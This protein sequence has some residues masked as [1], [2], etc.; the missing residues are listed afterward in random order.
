MN[1]NGAGDEA[2]PARP[3]RMD[4]DAAAV[5]HN[6]A[7]LRAHVGQAVRLFVALKGNACGFGTVPAARLVAASGADALAVVDV[8]D[9]VAIRRAGI[10]LPILL[11]G[12]NIATPAAVAAVRRFDMMPTLHDDVSVAGFANSATDPLRVFVEV[13][14]GGER[15]GFEPTAVPR[16]LAHLASRPWI[17]VAGI[18]AHMH[19][20]ENPSGL[21]VVQ[22]Q[23]GRF[24]ALLRDLESSGIRIPVQMTASSKTLLVSSSMNLTA[25]DPGHLVFGVHPGGPRR[26]ELGL[27][28]ALLR[29]TSR[30]VQVRCVTR[31]AFVDQAP[32]KVRPGQRIGVIPFGASD[33]LARVNAGV[34]LVRGKRVPLLGPPSAEHARLD[35]DEVPDATA[36]DEVTIIGGEAAATISLDEVC[37]H[38]AGVRESDVTRSIG[39]NIPRLYVEEAAER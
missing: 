16:L 1:S 28:P 5:R 29:L 36:G 21:A 19:V 20:P 22:W 33:G 3:N 26:P 17:T 13:N 32:S 34:V 12:G 35:L 6:I 24:H 4:V 14:V 23:F 8:G 30:L 31:P 18:Y 39:R 10:A 9:A 11:Y 37:R 2:P 25:V 27:R 7:A 38:Q 15:L